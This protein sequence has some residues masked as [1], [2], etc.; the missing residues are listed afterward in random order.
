MSKHAD[1]LNAGNAKYSLNKIVSPLEAFD[2]HGE[3]RVSLRDKTDNITLNIQTFSA[4][5][6]SQHGNEMITQT[7]TWRKTQCRTFSAGAALS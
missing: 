2:H 3:Q 1:H 7:H 5:S 6:D 4:S